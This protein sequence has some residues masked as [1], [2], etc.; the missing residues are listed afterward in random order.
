[1]DQNRVS[2]ARKIRQKKSKKTAYTSGFFTLRF[3][4]NNRYG[5]A[6]LRSDCTVFCLCRDWVLVNVRQI[7]CAH[8]KYLG[9]DLNA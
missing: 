2:E 3:Y 1:M 4:R 5:T 9:A 7:I 6:F 8:V